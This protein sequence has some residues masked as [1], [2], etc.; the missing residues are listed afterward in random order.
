MR[1]D[2][3]GLHLPLHSEGYAML[4]MFSWHEWLFF[5]RTLLFRESH[6]FFR[7]SKPFGRWTIQISVAHTHFV[8]NLL[9]LKGLH[10]YFLLINAPRC[11]FHSGTFRDALNKWRH[12]FQNSITRSVTLI[13]WQQV[14]AGLVGLLS[15]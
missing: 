12:L 8:E 15:M 3:W 2:G 9:C 11:L 7:P 4:T 6:W 5:W 1:L 10:P 14:I 13:R